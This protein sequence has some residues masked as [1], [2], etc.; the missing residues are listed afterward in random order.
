MT[1]GLRKTDQAVTEA[2]RLLQEECA[3]LIV[4]VNKCCRFGF[5]SVHYKTGIPHRS[6]MVTEIADVLTLIDILKQQGI[7]AEE[8]IAL[9]KN[10]KILKLK[11]WTN[12]YEQD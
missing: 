8:E 1:D 10:A 12:L 4:E 9:A 2:L 5:D 7:I 11:R 6:S 3:E